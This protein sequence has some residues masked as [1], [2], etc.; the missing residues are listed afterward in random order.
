M[1]TVLLAVVVVVLLF[2]APSAF[3]WHLAW[4]PVTTN[5]DGSAITDLAGYNAYK[6]NPSRAKINASVIP[7]SA[8]TGSPVECAFT[9]ATNPIDGDRYVVTAI[10]NSGQESGDS[11]I[12]TFVVAPR[13]PAALEILQ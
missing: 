3:A 10:D 9:L 5:V 12:A 13:A 7:P 6:L 8:C 2:T 11:N 1:K 4:G